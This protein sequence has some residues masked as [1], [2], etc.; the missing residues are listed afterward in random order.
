MLAA[1]EL[2]KPNSFKWEDFFKKGV[3]LLVKPNYLALCPP[4]NTPK[5]DLLEGFE[6]IEKVLS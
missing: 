2:S 4:L 1:I 6:I 3:H 5:A